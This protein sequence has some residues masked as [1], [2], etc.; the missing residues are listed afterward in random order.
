MK[1]LKPDEQV[2]IELSGSGRV[3]VR[4]VVILQ[5]TPT[6]PLRLVEGPFDDAS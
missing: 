2:E 5:T 3:I 1:K 6:T 4:A